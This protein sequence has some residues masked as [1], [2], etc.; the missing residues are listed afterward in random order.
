MVKK[1]VEQKEA[2]IRIIVGFVSGI[3]LYVWGVLIFVLFVVHWVMVLFSGKR[4]KGLADFCEYWNS[5]MYRFLR[6]MTFATN[7]RPFP[8]SE[9][10]RLNKF[11]R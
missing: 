5:E 9:M 4:D 10:V 11:E 3:V 8:F 1:E 7:V 2:L 6:Y